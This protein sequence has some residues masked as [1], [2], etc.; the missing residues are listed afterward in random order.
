MRSTILSI[1]LEFCW[2]QILMLRRKGQRRLDRGADLHDIKLRR[3][4]QQITARGITARRLEQQYR[5]RYID[6][7]QTA[8]YNTH[9]T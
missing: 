4:S 8:S 1:R 7:P 5:W 2:R 9:R 6:K 3:W